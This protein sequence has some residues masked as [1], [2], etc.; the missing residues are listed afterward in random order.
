MPASIWWPKTLS[1]DGRASTIPRRDI[2]EMAQAGWHVVGVLL[3][4]IS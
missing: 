1:G 2:A 3:L 4:A